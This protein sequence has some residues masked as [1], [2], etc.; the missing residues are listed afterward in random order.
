MP[1]ER[2][3][4][5]DVLTRPQRTHTEYAV[6]SSGH[7]WILGSLES[8]QGIT[9]PGEPILART[10]TTSQWSVLVDGGPVNHEGDEHE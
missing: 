4:L 8:A 5:V 9:A 10:V 7:L 3:T 2:V 1:A 6:H